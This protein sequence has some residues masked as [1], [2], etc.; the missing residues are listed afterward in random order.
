MYRTALE[1]AGTRR[2]GE[3]EKKLEE[4][5]Q[6]NTRHV[7]SL[8]LLGKVRY[9]L[10]RFSLSRKCFETVL[11]Y[12]PNNLP[13]YF[14]LQYF[15]ERSW[16]I[17]AIFSLALVLAVSAGGLFAGR[18]TLQRPLLVELSKLENGFTSRTESVNNAVLLL[19]DTLSN[20]YGTTARSVEGIGAEITDTTTEIIGRLDVLEKRIAGL[21]RRN[22]ETIREEFASGRKELL[23]EIRK[24]IEAFKTWIEDNR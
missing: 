6:E 5:L 3:A 23:R 19:A 7:P 16:K 18:I 17:A 1:M 24:E 10:R 11:V 15:K 8:L 9:Y 4:I 14:G 13:A 12:D 20:E 2:Y 21:E 22:A